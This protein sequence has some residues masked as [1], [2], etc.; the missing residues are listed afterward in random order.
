MVA[1]PLI[2]GEAQR[3]DLAEL[4]KRAN[5]QPVDMLAVMEQIKTPTGHE[6]HLKRMGT[7]TIA[8]P[9][10][11]AVTFTIE[12]GH[13]CGTC[14]HL[15]VSSR[16]RGRTPSPEAIWMIAKELGFIGEHNE[17]TVFGGCSFWGEDIGDGDKAI[18]IVQ[19]I[20]LT[21]AHTA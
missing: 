13:P 7:F 14:R 19:P 3:R 5:E 8:V 18:N 9:A 15:S 1:T 12:T 16:R 11:F 21:D 6:M 10:A 17:D 4:R 20:A 2:I